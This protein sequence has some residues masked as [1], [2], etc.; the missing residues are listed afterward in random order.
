M[1]VGSTAYAI[2]STPNNETVNSS[3]AIKEIHANLE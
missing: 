1:S 3:S 2:S